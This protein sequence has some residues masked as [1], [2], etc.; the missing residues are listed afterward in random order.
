MV[1][2]MEAALDDQLPTTDHNRVQA[3]DRHKHIISASF[4]ER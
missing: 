3:Y 1:F 2:P 4:P